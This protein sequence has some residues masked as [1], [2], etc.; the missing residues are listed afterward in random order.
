MGCATKSTDIAAVY[1]SPLQYQN[2]DCVQLGAESQRIQGRITQV[3]GRLDQAASNDQ[4]IT[5]ASA[6][7]FWPALFFLGGTKPQEAEFGRLKGEYDAVQ[8]AAIERRCAVSAPAPQL[9]KPSGS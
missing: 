8:Q 1:V 7:L 5:A 6:I 2:Y 3:G 4:G 9:Q